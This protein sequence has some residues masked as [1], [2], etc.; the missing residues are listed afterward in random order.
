MPE[1]VERK[2]FA[3]N[4]AIDDVDEAIARMKAALNE[5]N[6]AIEAAKERGVWSS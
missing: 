5:V 6:N 4:R 1:D 2:L 3:A